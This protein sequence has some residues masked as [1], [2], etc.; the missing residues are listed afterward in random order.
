MLNGLKMFNKYL[1]YF[2]FSEFF[3]VVTVNLTYVYV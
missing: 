2:L 3:L 1:L